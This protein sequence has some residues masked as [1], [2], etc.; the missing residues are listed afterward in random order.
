[1]R[2]LLNHVL[3]WVAGG[4]LYGLLEILHH[5]YTHWSMV[6]LAAMLCIPLDLAN[7]HIPWK[8]P[9]ALQA[10]LGGLTITA[11][12]L[13]AGLVLNVWLRLDIWD[14]SGLWGNLWGQICPQFAALWVMLAGVAIVLFDWMDYWR[15]GGDHPRYRLI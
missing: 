6:L 3:L 4:L 5:G 2:R 12:E 7:N 10:L 14:Y 13:V 8:M 9:L 15:G 11:A 1:M